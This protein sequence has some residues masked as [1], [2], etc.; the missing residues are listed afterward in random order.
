VEEEEEEEERSLIA[1]LKRHGGI[2]DYRI[3]RRRE[4]NQ[5]S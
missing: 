2:T 3:R 1:G 4:F 5:R